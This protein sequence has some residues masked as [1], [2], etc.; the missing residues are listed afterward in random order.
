[1]FRGITGSLETE[2]QDTRW[3][4]IPTHAATVSH[5]AI[6]SRVFIV[7][8]PRQLRHLRPPFSSRIAYSS[9]IPIETG[10]NLPDFEQ[11]G[12][13][14]EDAENMH[15]LIIKSLVTTWTG[16]SPTSHSRGEHTPHHLLKNG[17]VL[18]IARTQE[19]AVTDISLT[20]AEH[21]LWP[22]TQ[23]RARLLTKNASPREHYIPC[24]NAVIIGAVP[25]TFSV[26]LDTLIRGQT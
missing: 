21:A 17:G 14:G 3:C 6:L 4:C 19:L 22:W 8:L 18:L 16:R 1:M 26:Y 25:A 15:S 13:Q 20:S 24:G 11:L 5:L 7:T 2:H 9:S 10:S 23:G 12:R